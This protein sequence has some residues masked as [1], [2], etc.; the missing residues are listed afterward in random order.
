MKLKSIGYV[1][2]IVVL[3]IA[4]I[5]FI[6]IPSM[7]GFGGVK[8]LA[9][10]DGNSI[11]N[12]PASPFY[13]KL[14]YVQRM[15]ETF[16][17]GAPDTPEGQQY[18]NYQMTNTAMT[19]ALVDLA[20]QTEVE[21]CGYV[22]TDKL[23]NMNLIKQFSDPQTGLY[24]AEAYQKTPEAEKLK[25]RTQTVA[26]LKRSR[27]IQDVFGYGDGFGVKISSKEANF[28]AGMS[29]EKRSIQYVN[30]RPTSFPSEKVKAYAEEHADLFVK[31]DL[32]I[33]SFQ[34]EKAAT[35]VSKEILK[36]SVTFEEAMKN[37]S[38]AITNSYV[39]ANGALINSY[40]KDLNALFPNAED[41][42]KV[43]NLKAGEVSSPVKMNALYVVLKCNADP[44]QPDFTDTALLEQVS[45]YM[46]QYEKGIIEDYLVAHA[47]DFIKAAQ[48][49][50]F[51]DAALEFLVK[52]TKTEQF[53][54]NYG[55]SKFLSMLPTGDSLITSITRNE[56]FLKT[57]FSLK[58]GEFSKPFLINESAVV[59]VVDKITPAEEGSESTVS[60]YKSENRNWTEYYVLALIT[61]QFPLPIAQST[62]IDYIVSNPKAKNNLYKFEN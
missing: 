38:T 44:I 34:D 56:E 28:V 9:S 60:L 59:A 36:G 52:P 33:V 11:T 7:G 26:E 32:S 22:P 62:V 4:A 51:N 55:N 53:P 29:S 15:F 57:I 49:K 42:A 31:H 25:L 37:Q 24:S 18:F 1:L 23:V 40:R 13:T 17:G 35:T 10:W 14:Q 20:M 6:W 48:E 21:K 12:E 61:G 2:A 5:S 41:L 3:S 45:Y 47:N 27:Y 58:E 50:G 16:G 54:L 43:V 46:R 39:D 19:A 30:F 8:V